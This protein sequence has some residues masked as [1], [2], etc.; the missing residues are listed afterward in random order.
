MEGFIE[1]VRNEACTKAWLTVSWMNLRMRSWLMPCG[2]LPAHTTARASMV[3]KR[4]SRRRPF[5]LR[6]HVRS[7]ARSLPLSLPRALSHSLSNTCACSQVRIKTHAHASV[8]TGRRQTQAQTQAQQHS[9]TALGNTVVQRLEET[10]T[11]KKTALFRVD[12]RHWDDRSED[13][14]C[15]LA[16]VG[17]SG[18]LRE[19]AFLQT[20]HANNT[21]RV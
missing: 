14:L 8:D 2:R 20:A 7:R 4:P 19:P 13:T 18:P 6:K 9:A 5:Q 17:S 16:L 12:G 1:N 3:T 11:D 15:H 21:H 10:R